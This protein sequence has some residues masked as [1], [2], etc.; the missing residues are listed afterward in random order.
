[1]SMVSLLM[2]LFHWM[3]R[4]TDRYSWEHN[5]LHEITQPDKDLLGN[6]PRFLLYQIK[7]HLDTPCPRKSINFGRVKTFVNLQSLSNVSTSVK[8]NN[9]LP[10]WWLMRPLL[11]QTAPL[12]TWLWLKIQLTVRHQI[13]APHSGLKWPFQQMY[14]KYCFTEKGRGK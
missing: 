13:L 8:L 5:H 11:Y 12:P 2:A 6:L 14:F 4:T 7:S 1:M 3:R 10:F 9:G